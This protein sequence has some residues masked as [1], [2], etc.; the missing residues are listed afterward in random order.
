[1]SSSTNG[2]GGPAPVNYAG[3]SIAR[4]AELAAA[5]TLRIPEG[6]T[7]AFVGEGNANVVF[8]FTLPAQHDA[9]PENLKGKLLRVPKAGRGLSYPELQDYWERTIKPLF[10]PGDLIQQEL[11]RLPSNECF[12]MLNDC[13]RRYEA[14]GNRRADF[15]GDQVEATT[16]GMLI[17]DMTDNGGDSYTFQ[18]KPKW[19]VQSKSAPDDAVRCRNCARQA[20]RNAEAGHPPSEKP[21]SCPLNYIVTLHPGR[22]R[23]DLSH[24]KATPRLEDRF[25]RWLEVNPLLPR[26]QGAQLMHDVDRGRDDA[27]LAL[28]M[29]LRDCTCFVRFPERDDMPVVA[30]LGDLDRKDITA[31]AAKWW[32]MEAD[33]LSKGYYHA[34]ESPRQNTDCVLAPENR[35]LQDFRP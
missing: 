35:V 11:V 12:G 13:L 33:L 7:F 27:K 24:F 26:L 25:V 3:A 28:A 1:M 30:K 6:T 9:N 16:I 15:R 2:S 23:S 19:L 14:K 10:E 5:V 21:F 20:L 29:T 4:D 22:G 32:K 8:S 31:K 17:D 34:K 18:F